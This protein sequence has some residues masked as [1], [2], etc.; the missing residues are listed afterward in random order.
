MKKTN[1]EKPVAGAITGEPVSD[2]SRH[3]C[4]TRT[5]QELLHD[6]RVHEIEL[7]MQNDALRLSQAALEESRDSY[8]D[9]YDSA[10]IGHLTLTHGAIISQLNLTA[11]ELM[12]SAREDLLKQNFS[13]RV[14]ETDRALWHQL[15]TDAIQID[16]RKTAELTLQRNDGSTFEARVDCRRKTPADG[17]PIL[18]VALADISEHKWAV[19]EAKAALK[20]R[21]ELQDKLAAMADS[22]TR[23]RLAMQALTG[24]VYDWD[25]HS[26]SVHWSSGIG[27]LCGVIDGFVP[28]REQWGQRVHPEDQPRVRAAVL[29]AM[30]GDTEQFE[31]EY[32]FRH[33]D[34][35]LIHVSDRAQIVLDA[36]RKPVRWVGFVSDISAR[37]QAE[38]ALLQL[39]ESLE[40]KVAERGAEIEA[41]ATEGARRLKGLA[42]HL[43]TVREEQ[44]ASIAREVHDELGG[45]LTMLKLGLA[46]T[47][48]VVMPSDP[49]QGRLKIMQDQVNLA[50]Q[51][52]KRISVKLRPAMLDTLG[53]IDTI[54]WYAKQFSS[55]TRIP[56]VVEALDMPD[57]LDLTTESSTA[58]F[59]V[60]QE[61]LTN[62][63]KHSGAD[64]AK[65]VMRKQ[66][67]QLVVEISDNG[68]GLQHENM[69]RPDSFG[70]I[71]MLERIQYLGGHLEI[72]N[73]P[74]AG[75]CLT[76]TIPLGRSA[77]EE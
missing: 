48:D 6:L 38:S 34:G 25:L 19:D 66:D 68:I 63:A 72:C 53:L 47:A 28:T 20:D 57:H 69:N 4:E 41:R 36:A 44:S 51:T 70:V 23:Y 49:L 40:L 14:V 76:L 74:E 9:L 33:G 50:L 39:N 55:M 56:A 45:T 54:R 31:V 32:R 42:A 1:P 29:R 75:A 8:I 64:Q 21:N 27:R 18:R 13:F 10:P 73:R 59:R 58:I 15:F 52:I 65:I 37:K 7:E 60:V 26:D 30:R 16:A 71:G 11:A 35:R 5:V 12:G 3:V 67:N 43:E 17:P 22:E 61:A 2:S 77:G 46:T 62:V 24:V